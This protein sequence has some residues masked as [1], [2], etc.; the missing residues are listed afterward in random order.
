MRLWYMDC[1]VYCDVQWKRTCVFL[2]V[3]QSP[4]ESWALNAQERD[5]LQGLR[6]ERS[7]VRAARYTDDRP[8]GGGTRSSVSH[9]PVNGIAN[10]EWN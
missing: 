6:G 1:V 7:G 3:W 5:G 4:V 2:T 8:R 10:D 9:Q